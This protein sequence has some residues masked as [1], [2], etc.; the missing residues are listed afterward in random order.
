MPSSPDQYEIV[1]QRCCRN[2]TINNIVS[3]GQ[4]GATYS[5]VL[6][7]EAQVNSNGLCLNNSPTYNN[8]P[9]IIICANEPIN[10]DHSA[11]DPEGDQ[12]VYKFCSPL[13]GGGTNGT[14]GNPCCA[15][16]FNG[17][18]PDPDAP[19]PYSNVTFTAPT[20]SPTN[21]M[22]GNPQ[23][24]INPT[25]G[26]ITG[27]PDILGQFVVGVCVEE[28]RNG[29]LMSIV[30]R[31]FQFNVENCDPTVIADIQ[32]DEVI[33]EQEFVVN[34]C[35]N[36]TI[37]F[38][39]ESFQEQFI[40]FYDWE[41]DLQNGQVFTSN[42]ENATVT[43]PDIGTYQG[44]MILNDGSPCTDTAFINV[45]IF[46]EI[47]ADFSFAYDTC[48]AGEVSFTNL[49]TSGSGNITSND[50]FFF[51]GGT[52]SEVDPS[53]MFQVPGNL[54]VTLIVE[55]INGCVDETVEI[56]DWFPV[57]PL[58]II[59][60]STFDGCSPQDVFFNNLS[61]PIDSTYDIVWDFGDG[62]TGS[63]ISPTHLYENPGLYDVSL[64]VTSPIGCFTSAF[65]P[66]W[67]NVEPS[68]VADFIF[69][70]NNPTNFQPQVDFTDQSIDPIAWQWDFG[71]VGFSIDQN[72]T[73]TFPDTGLQEITLVVTHP[74]GCTDTTVQILSLIHI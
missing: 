26:L 11:S 16:D 51:G 53:H 3:P 50:W 71:G 23:V 55:D 29:N 41:F 52:S 66:D 34:S 25:T 59:E 18:A 39:N 10:F 15:D 42:Q 4:T 54:P 1:Y 7:P 64:S 62:T 6:T 73:F 35:G 47:N 33:G 57:P 43:F 21:P 70:P 74:S 32:N 46:P 30:R 40:D 48:I 13:S 65:F 61:V 31:D 68:P 69:S 5:I 14:G 20:Y 56:I 19:P 38:V 58:L 24:T 17:V 12:L 8:F 27:E 60:P 2:N 37:T 45:N 49:S 67:I 72:P 44:T 22:G 36:N 63:A 28:Y 9:P